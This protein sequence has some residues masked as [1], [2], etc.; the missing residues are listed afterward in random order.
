MVTVKRANVIL[1]VKESEVDRMVDL[2]Y[3]VID[4]KGDVI[5]QAVPSSVSDLQA[6]YHQHIAEIAELK[7]EIE[8]LKAQTSAPKKSKK[9]DNE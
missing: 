7:A 1:D 6:A 2:G 5:R 8:K 3:S 4:D 9:A